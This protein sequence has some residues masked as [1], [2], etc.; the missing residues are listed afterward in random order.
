MKKHLASLLPFFYMSSLFSV[1]TEEKEEETYTTKNKS[2]SSSSSSRSSTPSPDHPK[3]T[4]VLNS[5][6]YYN[7]FLEMAFRAL[8]LA[9]TLR[10]LGLDFA[11]DK[12]LPMPQTAEDPLEE[13]SKANTAK[14]K[15]GT[16]ERIKGRNALN[17]QVQ[18]DEQMSMHHCNRNNL[19]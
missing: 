10:S 8:Q 9:L 16:H 18:F 15:V 13:T 11:G 6:G 7:T 14:K 1:P 4:T 2:S 12:K 5:I 3:Y 19:S 17:L